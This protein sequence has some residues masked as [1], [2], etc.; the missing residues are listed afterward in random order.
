MEISLRVANIVILANTHN[1]SIISKEWL[2]EREVIE[3]AVVNFTHTPVF[4]I[5]ETNN[6]LF[7]VNPDRLE[8]SIKSTT[9]ENMENLPRIVKKYINRLPETPYTA[10][11]FNYIYHVNF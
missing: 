5:V 8:I 11:G 3:E 2:K 4:S 7:I 10:I 9:T 6:F 1:P